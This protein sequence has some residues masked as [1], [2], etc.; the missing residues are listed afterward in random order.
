MFLDSLCD[1]AAWQARYCRDRSGNPIPW[2]LIEESIRT[3]EPY[4]VFE[5]GRMLVVPFFERALYE[6]PDDQL[7]REGILKLADE[8]EEKIQGGLAPRPVLSVPH[9]LSDESSCYYHGYVLAEMSV[10]Q[11]RDYFF[12]E[13]GSIVDNPKVGEVLTEKYWKCG[14]AEMFF[15]LVEN[16][17]GKPL[18][19]DAW[20]KDLEEDIESK[21]K[22]EMA[23]YEQAVKLANPR[24]GGEVDLGM[25]MRLVDG[26]E[27]IAESGSGTSLL[28]ACEKFEKYVRDR[29]A[30]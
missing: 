16:L 20:V 28:Q 27:V 18:T 6:L 5:L 2:E 1:D 3:V 11:T 21:V 7:T 10:H 9:I 14:N 22:S 24:D 17:T 25:T 13:H 19:G 30:A 23:D 8:I 29:S 12:R 15:D 4:K 26:D